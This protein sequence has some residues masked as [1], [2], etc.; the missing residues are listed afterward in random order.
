MEYVK[1]K[2]L[3]FKIT[4]ILFTTISSTQAEQTLTIASWGGVYEKA[5]QTAWFNPFTKASGV[6]IQTQTYNGGLSI[7]EQDDL[8]DLIDMTEFDARHACDLGLLEPLN[9][10][11]IAPTSNDK[12]DSKSD[13]N[14]GTFSTCAIAHSTV[15]T[16]IAYNPVDFLARKPQTISDFFDIQRFPGKRGLRK[17]PYDFLEWALIAEGIPVS[18]IYD[19]L[20]TPRG[21]ELAFKKL[22]GIREHI[23]WWEN[24][25]EPAQLLKSKQVV[26]TSGFNGR[27]FA[28]QSLENPINLI[29]DG[30]II[31]KEVWVVPSKQNPHP[32]INQFLRFVTESKQLAALARLIPYGPTRQSAMWQIGRHPEYGIR[33]VDH[34]PTTPHNL[35]TA[36][37]RNVSWYAYTTEVRE[38]AFRDWLKAAD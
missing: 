34:L 20:S 36:L 26:M 33:M 9:Y 5:Q 25:E 15:A 12:F 21:I 29:W 24:P 19:M 14:P 18:Q 23:I 35:K 22:D 32:K 28:Q 1:K 10:S 37:F 16:L 4:C 13:F 31:D 3:W 38:K 27:F 7:L 17:E 6:T 11:L 8:P 30:Q 2:M